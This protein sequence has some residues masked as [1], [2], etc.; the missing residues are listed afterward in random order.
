MLAA[1]LLVPLM[2][3]TR[4]AIGKRWIP[5]LS[6]RDWALLGGIALVGMLA[7]STLMIF[8]MQQASGVT[9]SIVM[10]TT[11]AVTA[12]ASVL[13]LRDRPTRWTIGAVVLAVAG[14]V[15]VNLAGVG[16]D[17]GGGAN[18]LL[19]SALVFGA[20][21]GEAAYTLLGKRLTAD[22]RPIDIAAIAASL[23]IPL[24]IPFSIGDA[25]GFDWSAVGIGGWIALAWWG[26]GTL[27]LGTILWYLG[28]MDVTASVASGFMGAMP[29][30][31]LVLFY[32]LLGEAFEP[33]HL[34]GAA[35]VFAAI[36]LVAWGER[37]RERKRSAE[38]G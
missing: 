10:A 34:I 25:I 16:S 30:S 9:G 29:L 31:A 12:I 13:V 7:F 36:G 28:V 19:G 17:D 27:A 14:V 38:T 1:A 32:V 37:A 5:D 26:A 3:A 35:A 20:V 15:V 22:M 11:P 21:C 24:F 33:I 23:A 6:A 4:T 8:G 18:V 2:A